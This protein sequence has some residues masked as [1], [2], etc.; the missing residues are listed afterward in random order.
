MEDTEAGAATYVALRSRWDLYIRA[1]APAM[2]YT[3]AEVDP[4]GSDPEATTQRREF[5][6]RLRFAD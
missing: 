6:A 2:S 4:A 5:R 1:L 3:L